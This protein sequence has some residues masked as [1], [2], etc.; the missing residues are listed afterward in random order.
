MTPADPVDPAGSQEQTATDAILPILL[1]VQRRVTENNFDGALSLLF[2]TLAPELQGASLATLWKIFETSRVL[3][4]ALEAQTNSNIP[5]SLRAGLFT[6]MNMPT[7]ADDVLVGDMLDPAAFVHDDQFKELP[8]VDAIGVG[9]CA[10]RQGFSIV[11]SVVRLLRITALA[12]EHPEI[13]GLNPEDIQ[14]ML[15]RCEPVL[16]ANDP[17]L[18][19]LK[20]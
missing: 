10:F 8:Q 6:E 20:S 4:R 5:Q 17:R 14:A 16:Q 13:L 19:E 2:R 12:C 18:K 1:E 3:Y 11:D 15:L 7:L 9:R